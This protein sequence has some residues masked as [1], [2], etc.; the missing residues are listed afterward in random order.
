MSAPVV[1]TGAG[2]Q[3]GKALAEVFPEA[4]GLSRSN[5]DISTSAPAN[6]LSSLVLHSAAWTNVDSAELKEEYAY[7]VNVIGT[8]NVVALGSPVVGYSTDY[9]F[10]GT[11]RDPYVESDLAKPISAYGRTKLA[12]EKEISNGWVVRTSW[13]FGET[14]HNFVRTM[15]SLGESQEEVSVV[16]DQIGCPTYVGDLAAATKVLTGLPG[17]IWH[18]AAQGECSWADFAEAIFDAVDLPCRVRRISTL[19]MKRPAQRP[20]YSVIR[21]ERSGA[22]ELPHWHDGLMRCLS[23]LGVLPS[24]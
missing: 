19:E 16:S 6:L 11:K 2:G 5:W 10:D 4:V 14:G 1:I 12:A 3:L 15:L 23:R 17:G 24:G 18:L 13:L 7:E 9:V 8:R 22:P 21:S 20:A